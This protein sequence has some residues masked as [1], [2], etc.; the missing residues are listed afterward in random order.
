MPS[1]PNLSEKRLAR[2]REVV[3][4]RQKGI[5]LIVEDI[6]DPHN[7]QAIFRTCDALGIQDIC[8]I[9]DSQKPWNPRKLG[10]QSS[11]SA[12]K[13]LSFRTFRSTESC[14]NQL[15]KERYIIVGTVLDVNQT[16]FLS[17][18]FTK[19]ERI[20]LIVGN[21]HT[22][23]SSFALTNCDNLVY[24]PMKGMVE[25]LNV[26]VATALFLF[27]ITRQRSNLKKFQLTPSERELIEK[28]LVVRS[29]S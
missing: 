11:S 19:N 18:D 2:I 15:R 20:A 25:S 28:E 14:F 12:N 8:L 26:S 4:R 9:F 22:G 6:H 16:N 27:E 10:K 17:Y 29:R 7:A 5:V 24:F 1:V 3:A 13:W 21:E 23:L